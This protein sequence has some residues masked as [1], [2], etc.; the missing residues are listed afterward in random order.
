MTKCLISEVSPWPVSRLCWPDLQGQFVTGGC[1]C[2]A[3][4]QPQPG[5]AALAGVCSGWLWLHPGHCGEAAS[6]MFCFVSS[7]WFRVCLPCNSALPSTPLQNCHENPTVKNKSQVQIQWFFSQ[8]KCSNVTQIFVMEKQWK[9]CDVFP[10]FFSFNYLTY[11]L[12]LLEVSPS[13]QDYCTR[14]MLMLNDEKMGKTFCVRG[15][16]S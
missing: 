3:S 5:S 6:V 10:V 16:S 4:L 12:S 9:K 1:G 14:D 7:L 8:W 2:A 15:G 11:L 13:S